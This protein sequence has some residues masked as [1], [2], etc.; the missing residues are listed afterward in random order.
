MRS[1]R[2]RGAFLAALCFFALA[3]TDG[4]GRPLVLSDA[5]LGAADGGYEDSRVEDPSSPPMDA[6]MPATRPKDGGANPP[7]PPQPATCEQL[8]DT[9]SREAAQDAD[10][11][12]DVLD[13]MRENAMN[14]CGWPPLPPLRRNEK[15]ECSARLGASDERK[16]NQGDFM[17]RAEIIFGR[18]K[19][20]TGRLDRA[21]FNDATLV[22]ELLITS[23]NSLETF[24][25]S[26]RDHTDNRNKVC[27]A[28]LADPMQLAGA[29]R[30]GHVWVVDIAVPNPTFPGGP[31]G[32]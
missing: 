30:K 18:D 22:L 2:S 17:P 24:I 19:D 28:A 25:N 27:S 32:P 4:V 1:P 31:R 10:E 20:F 9:W 11:L 29:A 13:Y 14:V 26:I 15:L 3:C 23:T 6:T 12:L 8:G 5:W 16:Q 7:K 21:G